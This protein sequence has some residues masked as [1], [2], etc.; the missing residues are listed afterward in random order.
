V[1]IFDGYHKSGQGPRWGLGR[2]PVGKGLKSGN[3]FQAKVNANGINML[4]AM[5]LL[6]SKNLANVKI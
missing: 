2:Q 3:V 5:L 4:K 1:S 6:I